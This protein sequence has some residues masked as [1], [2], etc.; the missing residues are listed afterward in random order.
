M[1][2]DCRSLFFLPAEFDV[3]TAAYLLNYAQSREDLARMVSGIVRCL[4]PG[5]RFVT[6]NA[7]P[8]LEFGKGA[9]YR[10]F[11]FKEWVRWLNSRRDCPTPRYPYSMMLQLRWRTTGYPSR[12]TKKALRSAGFVEVRW[13]RPRSLPSPK[14]GMNPTIG[15]TSWIIPR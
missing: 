12:L 3:A 11:G 9:I 15:G 7:N 6:M 4:K 2:K 5:G 14:W 10:K 13:H 8:D 1:V